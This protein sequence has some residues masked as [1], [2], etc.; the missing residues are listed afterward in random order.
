MY[1]HI[2]MHAYKNVSCVYNIKVTLREGVEFCLFVLE[3]GLKFLFV[4]KGLLSYYLK[5]FMQ[6][7]SIR[8]KLIVLF[9]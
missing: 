5:F 9:V 2:Q 4:L 8:P 6:L 7:T 1:I 3:S